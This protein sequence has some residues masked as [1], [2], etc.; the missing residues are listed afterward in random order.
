VEPAPATALMVPSP[1]PATTGRLFSV[2]AR[3]AKGDSSWLLDATT[4]RTRTPPPGRLHMAGRG[5]EDAGRI[6]GWL[7]WAQRHHATNAVTQYWCGRCCFSF[8]AKRCFSDLLIR[9]QRWRK[10]S[11]ADSRLEKTQIGCCCK[12]ISG[13]HITPISRRV[14]CAIKSWWSFITRAKAYK[15]LHAL[16]ELDD[17]EEVTVHGTAVVHRDDWGL[18][19]VDTKETHPVLATTVGV[20]IG[21]LLGALA[22]PAGAAVG[23]AGGAAIGA[24]TG[25]VVG[26]TAADTRDKCPTT[27][28]LQSNTR[29]GLPRWWSMN[30][31]KSIAR[32][33]PSSTT[34]N[35]LKLITRQWSKHSNDA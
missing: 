33:R 22:G 11:G 28:S 14:R 2:T 7:Q 21:A 4:M 9:T 3:A 30:S 5:V 8:S 6:C 26:A 1:P 19:V 35:P 12:K 29:L 13:I 27:L 25:S 20:G 17:A 16:W 10:D 32:F 31:S 34:T 24:A 18:F 15:A 23:A